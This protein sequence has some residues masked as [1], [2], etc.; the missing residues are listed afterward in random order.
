MTDTRQAQDRHGDLLLERPL[1]A[2]RFRQAIAAGRHDEAVQLLQR[3]RQFPDELLVAELISHAGRYSTRRDA[4]EIQLRG[5]LRSS[6][7]E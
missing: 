4:L 7:V 6:R 1:L 3:I 5:I 2:S